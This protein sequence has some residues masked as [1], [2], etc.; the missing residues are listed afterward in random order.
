MC[1]HS[2]PDVLF[3]YLSHL[4]SRGLSKQYIEKID[5]YIAKYLGPLRKYLPRMLKR[6]YILVFT[7]YPEPEQGIPLILG[8]SLG[9]TGYS[10]ISG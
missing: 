1:L 2:S 3:G 4:E 8:D 6:S 5:E 9:F 10:S 7:S